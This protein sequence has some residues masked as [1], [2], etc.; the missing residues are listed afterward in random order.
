MLN[1]L[2]GPVNLFQPSVLLG[3]GPGP[4]H[5]FEALTASI[6]CFLIA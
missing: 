5:F 6:F 4:L 3:F 2:D 1:K